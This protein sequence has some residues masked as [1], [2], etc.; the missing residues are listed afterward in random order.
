MIAKHLVVGVLS[1]PYSHLIFFKLEFKT[2][3]IIIDFVLLTCKQ[4]H[5]FY[6][7]ISNCYYL[8]SI[9]KMNLSQ[10]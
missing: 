1:I 8:F 6:C 3:Q 2:N 4:L 7:T 10:G 5:I 9:Y